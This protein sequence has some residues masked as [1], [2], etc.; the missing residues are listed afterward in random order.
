MWTLCVDHDVKAIVILSDANEVFSLIDRQLFTCLF[1]NY[2]LNCAVYLISR[3]MNRNDIP[4]HDLNSCVPFSLQEIEWI[5][6]KGC[7]CI[8]APYNLTSGETGCSISGVTQ[9]KLLIQT[10]VSFV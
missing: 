2:Q 4:K 9:D 5:P 8:C 3:M 1:L 7:S 10:D 6:K